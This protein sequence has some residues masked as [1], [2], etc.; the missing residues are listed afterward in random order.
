MSKQRCIYREWNRQASECID[1]NEKKEAICFQTK[2]LT[3][4]SDDDGISTYLV[5]LR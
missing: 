3:F 1:T 5:A 2:Y 4:V